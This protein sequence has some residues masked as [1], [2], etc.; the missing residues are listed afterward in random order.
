MGLGR[1]KEKSVKLVID[2][3]DEFDV[4]LDDLESKFEDMLVL[5]TAL[6]KEVGDMKVSKK[7]PAKKA[8]VKKPA[9]KKAVK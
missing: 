2:G 9:K 3:L 6:S 8:P 4:R 5:I 1:A 7:A